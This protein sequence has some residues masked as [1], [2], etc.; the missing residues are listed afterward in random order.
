MKPLAYVR[1]VLWS[2]FGI[3]RSA[4]AGQELP[5]AKPAVVVATAVALAAVFGLGLAGLAQLAAASL[6]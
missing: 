2:F 5:S 4:A 3:R 1:M 6:G